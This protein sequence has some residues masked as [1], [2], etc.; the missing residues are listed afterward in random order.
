VFKLSTNGAY[1]TVLKHFTFV[2]G[3]VPRAGLTLS[4]NTLYGTTTQGGGSGRGT[5]FKVNT[6]GTGYRVLKH[7]TGGD[8]SNPWGDLT[9][10]GSALYGTTERGGSVGS[11]TVFRI[12]LSGIGFVAAPGGSMI[13]NWID[14]AFALQAAAEVSGPYTNVPGATSPY[15]NAVS[16]NRKFFRLVGN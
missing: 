8:G 6:D 2:D 1:Y 7:F 4:R 9:L 11:G 13:L 5:V 15:T 16:G 3:I 10:S 14:S 12:D